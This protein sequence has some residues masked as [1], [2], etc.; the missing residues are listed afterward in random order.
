MKTLT[1]LALML[2]SAAGGVLFAVSLP[3]TELS[4][5]P[6]VIVPLTPAPPARPKSAEIADQQPIGQ[7]QSV[8]GASIDALAQGQASTASENTQNPVSTVS[9]L[10]IGQAPAGLASATGSGAADTRSPATTQQAP[11]SANAVRS[12]QGV[13]KA[14]APGTQS[15]SGRP[16]SSPAMN[17]GTAAR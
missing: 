1:V 15:V 7:Q 13:A 12:G 9:G 10:S 14:P 6:H 4:G 11:V 5:E 8:M 17:S 3:K 2:L 16:V